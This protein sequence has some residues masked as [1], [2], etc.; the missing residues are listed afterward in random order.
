MG[1][2]QDY[3]EKGDER[4]AP[5]SGF[6]I[7]TE[8]QAGIVDPYNVYDSTLLHTPSACRLYLSGTCRGRMVCVGSSRK[9][10]VTGVWEVDGRLGRGQS[11]TSPDS[12]VGQRKG[13]G[14]GL[15]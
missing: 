12:R 14:A 11:P 8:V 15:P 3:T 5:L 10:F 1:V 7:L 13:G 2:E 4:A 9:T 6:P